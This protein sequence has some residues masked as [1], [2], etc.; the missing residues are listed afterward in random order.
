[1]ACSL[2]GYPG[3]SFLGADRRQLG[4][5]AVRLPSSGEAFPRFSLKPGT[6]GAGMLTT[7]DNPSHCSRARVT[8]F[9]RVFPPSQRVALSVRHGF[10]A[11]TGAGIQAM[12]Q[13]KYGRGRLPPAR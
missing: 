10:F 2:V 8:T 6:V 12:S 4:Q 11:C 7:S 9:I 3:V 1:M 13:D 5:P